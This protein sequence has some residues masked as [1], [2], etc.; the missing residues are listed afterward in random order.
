MG[1]SKIKASINHNEKWGKSWRSHN[2]NCLGN[3]IK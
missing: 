1:Q 2:I 3:A